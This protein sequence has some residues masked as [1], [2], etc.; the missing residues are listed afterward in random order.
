MSKMIDPKTLSRAELRNLHREMWG[1]LAE[2]AQ[3]DKQHWPRWQQNGDGVTSTYTKCFACAEA[4]ARCERCPIWRNGVHC[5]DHNSV[6]ELWGSA[7]TVHARAYRARQVRDAWPAEPME[8]G[9]P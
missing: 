2:N 4:E 3:C 9:T 1:W 8:G 7:P 6:Y 5:C